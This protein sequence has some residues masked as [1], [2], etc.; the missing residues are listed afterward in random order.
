VVQ[1]N[2]DEIAGTL[3]QI[4]D[5]YGIYFDGNPWNN[6]VA[7]E[8]DITNFRVISDYMTSLMQSWI[9]NR[10]FFVV[11]PRLPAFFG[12]QLVLISR[13][14]NVIAEAVNEVRFA[15]DSV[16]I[17]P[18]ERQMLLLK[19]AGRT[20]PSMYLEDVLEEVD[21]FV[22]NEGPR[23]L[24]D[25]GKISVTNNILPVV[26]ELRD[27]IRQTRDQRDRD[28]PRGFKTARVRRSMDD[29]YGQLDALIK[30]TEQVEQ[31]LPIPEYALGISG[32]STPTNISPIGPIPP[33]GPSDPLGPWSF[34]IYG[35]AFDPAIDVF[36]YSLV[37]EGVECELENFWSAERVDVTVTLPD[38]FTVSSHDIVVTNPDGEKATSVGALLWD[39]T[40]LTA[41][42]PNGGNGN[43]GGFGN[44][45]GN[46][47]GDG[48]SSYAAPPTVAA[49]RVGRSRR[50]VTTV[51]GSDLLD[52]SSS[53]GGTTSPSAPS[54]QSAATAASDQKL[55]AVTGNAE[56]INLPAPKTE[57][58]AITTKE[59]I[60]E[61]L[62]KH[63]PS[64]WERVKDEFEK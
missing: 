24:R 52:T 59:Q 8:Q 10:Q 20:Y 56:Q 18:N 16:F 34:S 58:T 64:L 4:R 14:F 21:S 22:A 43:S 31:Q 53:A 47:N 32:I 15:L 26:R 9:A 29:L 23:L 60:A 51:D 13:Q 62:K 6:T 12:T 61:T 45:Y 25:G 46:G 63:Q 54:A 39:G 41:A 3:G 42:A 38:A 35:S 27:M 49:R 55:K 1:L 2:P 37:T 19:F 50:V 5:T 33:G 11:S 30:L 28:V 44:G 7:D 17:G 40:N 36:V 57:A 48:G